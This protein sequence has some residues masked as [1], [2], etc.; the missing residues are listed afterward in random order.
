MKARKC[1]RIM[2]PKATSPDGMHGS[3][4]PAVSRQQQACLRAGLKLHHVHGAQSA[5]SGHS[6]ALRTPHPGVAPPASGLAG[7][8]GHRPPHALNGGS[9][10]RCT[11]PAA[12]TRAARAASGPPRGPP[13]PHTLLVVAVAGLD[14]PPPPRTRETQRRSFR[15]AAR[16]RRRDNCSGGTQR[17]RGL[18]A[19][20]AQQRQVEG[21][22]GAWL[23]CGL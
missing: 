16:K 12:C 15:R 11:P 21:R 23:P 6:L 13:H 9:W 2:M 14:A 3:G 1:Y 20:A 4:R 7:L 22:I 17:R 19:S 5:S 10:P 18:A 8:G